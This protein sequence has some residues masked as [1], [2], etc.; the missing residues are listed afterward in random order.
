M[1]LVPLRLL[2]DVDDVLRA[3]LAPSGVPVSPNTPADLLQRL[4]YTVAA[5]VPGG[6]APHPALLDR[7]TVQV[8]CYAGS[9]RE[10]A[11]LA[12]TC[13]VLLWTAW[14]EQSTHGGAS[15]ARFRGISEPAE[16]RTSGQADGLWRFV[17]TYSLHVRP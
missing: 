16:L 14:R 11:D 5:R 4:P 7:A 3:V 15:I 6:P 2:A 17:A 10:A 9:R 13:R 1:S 8:D 12:E